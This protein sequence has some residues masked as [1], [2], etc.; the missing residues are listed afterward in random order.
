MAN[1]NNKFRIFFEY[2]HLFA[3][4]L[5]YFTWF[6]F[7]Y[8]SK[9]IPF[10]ESKLIGNCFNFNGI[11]VSAFGSN[12]NFNR[13]FYKMTLTPISAKREPKMHKLNQFVLYSWE[14]CNFPPS[15]SFTAICLIVSGSRDNRNSN[16][17]NILQTWMSKTFNYFF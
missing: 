3:S 16:I 14:K 7:I 2:F 12:E 1:F 6:S 17:P 10:F 8:C 11:S 15:K 13:R 4:T 9:C 5:I